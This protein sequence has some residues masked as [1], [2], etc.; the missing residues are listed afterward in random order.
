MGFF[1]KLLGEKNKNDERLM[2]DKRLEDLYK[3]SLKYAARRYDDLDH[4][5][6]NEME[7]LFFA[8][9]SRIGHLSETFG[10]IPLHKMTNVPAEDIIDLGFVRN[11]RKEVLLFLNTTLKQLEKDQ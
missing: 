5:E 9:S 11:N 1:S 6:S 8:L 4:S 2:L 7:K 3:K 10:S